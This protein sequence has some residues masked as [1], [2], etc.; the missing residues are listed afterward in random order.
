MDLL[1]GSLNDHRSS[2]TTPS[3]DTKENGFIERQCL[4]TANRKSLPPWD[5]DDKVPMPGFSPPGKG[6]YDSHHKDDSGPEAGLHSRWISAFLALSS[7]FQIQG[8]DSFQTPSLILSDLPPSL[9][10]A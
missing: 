4:L 7:M 1:A 3:Y 5:R 6:K 2:S 10:K 9:V 8:H